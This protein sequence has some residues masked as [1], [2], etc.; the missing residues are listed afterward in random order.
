MVSSTTQSRLGNCQ[1]H[2]EPR[3]G[4][5]YMQGEC[6]T[7]APNERKGGNQVRMV[8]VSCEIAILVGTGTSFGWHSAAPGSQRHFLSSKMG[9]QRASKRSE[10]LPKRTETGSELQNG[11]QRG[12]EAIRIV[13]T[14]APKALRMDGRGTLILS[15]LAWFW[16][17]YEPLACSCGEENH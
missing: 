16:V 15:D 4:Q 14:A 12:F 2:T 11:T 7:N 17:Y 3:A 6:A 8:S 13:A 9:M 5:K 10:L 1:V